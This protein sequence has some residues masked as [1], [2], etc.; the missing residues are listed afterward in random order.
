MLEK[1]LNNKT[2]LI[3][4]ASRLQGIGAAIA[5]KLAEDGADIFFTY[6]LDYD[7]KMPWGAEKE[8]GGR[9]INLSSG[10]FKGPMENEMAY[11]ATKGAVDALTISLAAEL[12]PKGITV[13]AVN[14]GP[15]DTGWMGQ[16]LKEELLKKFPQG[17]I[18]QPE[19]TARLVSFLASKDAEW[20]TGEII[21]SEG[22]F[23]R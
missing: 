10:Q 16:E 8:R 12:A 23:K 13:N 15:T 11:A 5:R 7:R 20:I 2:A 19:D 9:I 3:T 21:N 22:G 18:G 14:P 1:R 17:R 6:W 4:G